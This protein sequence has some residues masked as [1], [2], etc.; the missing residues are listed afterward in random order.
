MLADAESLKVFV[1]ILKGLGID[2][3][4]K[5]NDR[6]LLD[7]ALV[8]K[9]GCDKSKFNTICSSIDKLDKE[10]WENIEK[11]LSEKGLTSENIA[12]I[13]RFIDL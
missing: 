12:E 3:K 11:E 6:R 4:I 8:E 9:A 7:I 1:T 10:P 13:K 5:L 2:F